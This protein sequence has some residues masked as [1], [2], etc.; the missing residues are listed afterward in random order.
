MYLQKYTETSITYQ[1]FDGDLTIDDYYGG[2]GE[3]KNGKLFY[4][5]GIPTNLETL[6]VEDYFGYNYDNVKVSE[7]NVKGVIFYSLDLNDSTYDSLHKSNTTLSRNSKGGSM[8]YESVYY[9]YV[10]N[11][12]TI[13]GKGKTE[14]NN[15]TADEGIS[16][17]SGYLVDMTTIN[18][19]P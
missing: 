17:S 2:S 12:I 5:I 4:T 6:N 14:T 1:E 3:V 7:Q 16:Y 10:D 13:S 15:G 19:A 9:V 18:L 11:N 8:T